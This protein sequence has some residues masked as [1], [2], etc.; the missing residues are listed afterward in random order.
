M[1]QIEIDG[2]VLTVEYKSISLGDLVVKDN[3]VYK[4][5]IMDC[6]DLGYVIVKDIQ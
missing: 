4:A 3:V 2:I 5:S 6:D 1:E